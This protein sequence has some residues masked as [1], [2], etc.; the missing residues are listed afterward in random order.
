MAANT[1]TSMIA[2]T[3]GSRVST[4]F[5]NTA[6]GYENKVLRYIQANEE[7]TVADITME[8]TNGGTSIIDD[9]IDT[10]TVTVLKPGTLISFD[11]DNTPGYVTTTSGSFN[12]I[13]YVND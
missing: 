5:D 9:Y 11:Q 3:E 8:D 4:T 13:Y 10:S 6:S 7:I 12:F 2:G 1:P